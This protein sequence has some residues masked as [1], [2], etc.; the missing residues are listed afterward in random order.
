MT[1]QLT[2]PTWRILPESVTTIHE[3]QEYIRPVP[4]GD[5]TLRELRLWR[6]T[7]CNSLDGLIYYPRETTAC[8]TSYVACVDCGARYGYAGEVHEQLMAEL[9]ALERVAA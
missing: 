4:S 3:A 6:C 8:W 1:A 7:H 2:L 9:A 5:G